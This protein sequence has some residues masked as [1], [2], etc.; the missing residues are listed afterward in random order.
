MA[1]VHPETSK[2]LKDSSGSGGLFYRLFFAPSRHNPV[3]TK[4]ELRGWYTYEVAT[5]GFFIGT[6]DLVSI[7]AVGQAGNVAKSIW[8]E[9]LKE[10]HWTDTDYSRC[11]NYSWATD[12]WNNGT[13]VGMNYM[14]DFD[15]CNAA[16]GTWMATW[17]PEATMVP[18]FGLNVGYTATYSSALT[19]SIC[20]QLILFIC[21]GGIADYG[22][23]RRTVFFILNTLSA[24]AVALIFIGGDS[25]M[26]QF[27][28]ACFIVVQTLLN[29]AAILYNAW[30]PLL[31]SNMP[32][33]REL[34]SHDEDVRYKLLSDTTAYI[35]GT[36][37]S[38]G[39][40]AAV[41]YLGSA[42]L[43][44]II[45]GPSLGEGFIIRIICLVCGCWLFSLSF[46]AFALLEA[47]PGDPFPK[48]E[49]ILSV[50]LKRTSSTFAKAKYLPNLF[51]F[52]FSY[53]IYSDGVSTLTGASAV[54]ASEE[55]GI[56]YSGLIGAYLLFSFVAAIGASLMVNLQ[57]RYNIAK[58]KIL[59]TNLLVCLCLPLYGNWALTSIWE[60]FMLVFVFGCNYGSIHVFTRSLYSSLLPRGHE[61]EFFSLYQLTDKGTAWAGPLLMSVVSSSTGSFRQAFA[62]LGL[63]FIFGILA[64][65]FVDIDKAR[66]EKKIYE[67]NEQKGLI[68]LSI[69]SY[70]IPKKV[71]SSARASGA[72]EDTK[73]YEEDD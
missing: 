44:L 14:N 23:L 70:K 59:M 61:A 50:G 49:N 62:A 19:I 45:A 37:L 2:D 53:F 34:T 15:S 60:Y 24:I 25:S 63:F 18:L 17:I 13:C 4:R 31:A 65:W 38:S 54:F 22:K 32:E 58:K 8:C 27:N 28:L 64:L 10:S 55:L 21:F 7:F 71:C 39:F 12:F 57:Q 69:G 16:D 9:K 1:S 35:A 40:I 11:L 67:D 5:A 6:Q 73:F 47:R 26:Y 20:F 33:V 66:E 43:L 68:E 3:T 48:G 72:D 41:G 46:Y 29:F 36:G 56:G 30:L 42:A 52:L 51:K